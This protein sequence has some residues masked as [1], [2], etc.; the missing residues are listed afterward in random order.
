MRRVAPFALVTVVLASAYPLL[1]G[2]EVDVP[3]TAVPNPATSGAIVV[4]PPRPN[5]EP[6]SWEYIVV[7]APDLWEGPAEGMVDEAAGVV[8]TRNFAGLGK[9]GWE[10]CGELRGGSFYLFKRPAG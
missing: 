10:Y 3:E 9:H 2:Q 7:K 6:P 4:D 1:R 8:A 5:T